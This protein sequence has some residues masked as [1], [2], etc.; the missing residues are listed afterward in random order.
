MAR[1]T[2][3][4]LETDSKHLRVA[5]ARISNKSKDE[6]PFVEI[7][8]VNGFGRAFFAYVKDRDIERFAVN[9]LKALGSKK[10]VAKEKGR[11]PWGSVCN[12]A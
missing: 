8:M 10:L 6:K 2:E 5:E 7:K 4:E 11:K 12:K 1:K 3:F 9:I